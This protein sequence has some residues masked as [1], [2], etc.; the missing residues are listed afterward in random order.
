MHR[1][2]CSIAWWR[3]MPVLI[4]CFGTARLKS[5]KC[6]TWCTAHIT[7]GGEDLA[8]TA[9]FIGGSTWP[10]ARRCSPQ[11]EDL[12]RADAGLSHVGLQ[13]RQHHRRGR[14]VGGGTACRTEGCASAGAGG[15]GARGFAR[16]AAAGAEGAAVR[17]GSPRPWPGRASLQAVREPGGA[18]WPARTPRGR[19]FK[20]RF[21]GVQIVI[22]AG[23][24]GVELLSAELQQVPL[25][26]SRHR[27]RRGASV[28]VGWRR[29]DPTKPKDA[30]E[31][32]L[33]RDR[34]RGHEDENPQSRD[35]A[36]VHLQRSSA[37]CGRRSTAS[38]QRD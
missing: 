31:P 12:L 24:A 7:R 1:P 16:G 37:R 2:A 9:I 34:R 4:I 29:S 30:T 25:A 6:A 10:P 3:S 28:G 33:R 21:D 38:G 23:A 32:G 26:A 36:A 35:S 22:A 17:V 19:R 20:R 15:D 27:S 11:C 14:G 13:R 5:S 8:N 18:A